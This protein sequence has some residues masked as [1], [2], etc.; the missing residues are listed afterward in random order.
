MATASHAAALNHG[1]PSEACRGYI[2]AED[3]E[4]NRPVTEVTPQLH[5]RRCKRSTAQTSGGFQVS[6]DSLYGNRF[7]FAVIRQIQFEFLVYG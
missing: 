4:R 5:L 6:C 1:R 7:V 2:G 3:F